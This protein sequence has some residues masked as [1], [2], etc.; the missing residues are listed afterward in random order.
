MGR[1][2]R[3]LV[4]CRGQGVEDAEGAARE[5]RKTASSRDF[6]KKIDTCLHPRVKLVKK[7]AIIQFHSH[8]V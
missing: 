2:D 1:Y 6:I 7:T 8:F 3:I 4:K 5:T